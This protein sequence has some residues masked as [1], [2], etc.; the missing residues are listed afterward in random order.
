MNKIWTNICPFLAQLLRLL[1]KNIFSI[2]SALIFSS[3]ATWWY[4][5]EIRSISYLKCG[6]KK[7]SS[8]NKPAENLFH[9]TTFEIMRISKSYE[10]NV[11]K[12]FIF[13]SNSMALKAKKIK[14]TLKQWSVF[15]WKTPTKS[16]SFSSFPCG[17]Y[18][19]F[20]LRL[21]KKKIYLCS[22]GETERPEI[23]THFTIWTIWC[24]V[25]TKTWYIF[26]SCRF[27]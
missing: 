4:K 16:L 6:T 25:S 17:Y 27:V 23:W 10:Y 18:A 22:G 5:Y 8:S 15:E 21:K 19:I 7:G 24:L 9:C 11:T 12:Q 14:F 2:Y 3:K 1:L 26:K 20:L 13:P